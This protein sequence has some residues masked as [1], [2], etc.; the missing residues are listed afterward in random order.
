MNRRMRLGT[1]LLLIMVP[2]AGCSL[3]TDYTTTVGEPTNGTVI[4]NASAE[5]VD[6]W[7]GVQYEIEYNSSYRDHTASYGDNSSYSFEVYEH[8]NGSLEFVDRSGFNNIEPATPPVYQGSVS[9][10]WDSG[11]ERVY[12]IRVVN[13]TTEAVVDAVTVTIENNSS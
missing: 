11:E 9:P 6:D 10:P 2:L 4:E 5:F 7:A 12:E 3:T 8:V 13:E 1:V